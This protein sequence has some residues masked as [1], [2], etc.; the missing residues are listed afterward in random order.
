[1][2]ITYTN[3]K[4]V[5]YTLCRTTTTAGATRLVFARAPRGQPVDQLPAGHTIAESVNGQVSLVKQRPAMIAPAEGEAVVAAVRRHPRAADYR[6]EVKGKQITVYERVGPSIEELAAILSESGLTLAAGRLAATGAELDR[7]AQFVPV[8]RFLLLD[9]AT[10]TFQ[11][12]RWCYLGSIDGWLPL[13][14][15][16]ELPLLAARRVRILGTDAFFEPW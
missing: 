1:M 4:G 12:E 14:A 16:G 8:L 6:V 11:A 5:T 2:P 7:T 9:P 3:R 10:R 15:S 13:S